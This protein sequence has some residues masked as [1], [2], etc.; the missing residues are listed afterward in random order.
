MPNANTAR[1]VTV[2]GL[3]PSMLV[4]RATGKLPFCTRPSV[5]P[6]EM[7]DL[8][9]PCRSFGFATQSLARFNRMGE[10]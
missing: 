3:S 6:S 2:V 4:Y 9:L 7:P 10:I 8:G 1:R 5:A